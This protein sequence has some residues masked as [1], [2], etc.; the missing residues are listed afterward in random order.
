MKQVT[1]AVVFDQK[2]YSI[3]TVYLP[4]KTLV[5]TEKLSKDYIME[6]FVS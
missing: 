1:F 6:G 5:E 2:Q 4:E 3:A